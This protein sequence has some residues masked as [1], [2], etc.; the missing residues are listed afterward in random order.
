MLRGM[1]SL[2]GFS[3]AFRRTSMDRKT[4]S[5]QPR[6][7]VRWIK[8]SGAIRRIIQ[9]RRG[10]FSSNLTMHQARAMQKG[11][12]RTQAMTILPAM[13]HRT[14][15]SRLVAPTPR[16]AVETTWVVL[17]GRPQWLE[18]RMIAADDVSAAKPV[19]G[20]E[21]Q[22]LDAQGLDDLPSRRRWCRSPWRARR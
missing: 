12:V 8:V 17:T 21:L 18:T 19:N 6:P 11:S 22:H 14:A 20:L 16:M 13:P 5:G 4:S 3:R 2:P 15:E 10:Y 9:K 1:R 7:R